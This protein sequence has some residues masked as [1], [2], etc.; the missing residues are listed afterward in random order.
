MGCDAV[1]LLNSYVKFLELT[2][3]PYTWGSRQIV[4]SGCWYVCIKL[5]EYS[6]NMMA[7][8]DAREVKWRGNWWMEWVASIL[9]TTS[10]HGVSNIT[11]A[12]AQTSAASSRRRFKWTRHFR[13][14]TKSGV[15]A[16]AITFQTQS[17]IRCLPLCRIQ[18]PSL[19]KML[20]WRSEASYNKLQNHNF[21]IT[22]CK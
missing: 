22:L 15:C 9:H 4:N 8:G 5:L 21:L 14:K 7:Y 17:T 6:W 19:M 11:T 20:K 1:Y 2:V 18:L 3:W 10:E 13:R 12:D 16:C